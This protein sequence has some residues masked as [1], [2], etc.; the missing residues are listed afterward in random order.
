MDIKYVENQSQNLLNFP[1]YS[2]KNRE[3]VNCL[4]TRSINFEN[5]TNNTKLRLQVYREK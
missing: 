1:S 3:I 2:E 5:N 4:A